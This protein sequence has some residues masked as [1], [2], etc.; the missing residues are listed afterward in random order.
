[1]N[2][3]LENIPSPNIQ[4]FQVPVLSSVLI[5]FDKPISNTLL[6]L[7]SAAN[8][9]DFWYNWLVKHIYPSLYSKCASI[10]AKLVQS[11][12]TDDEKK[13]TDEC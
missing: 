12:Y 9:F 3:R 7:I 13:S 1:M 6:E 5:K 10:N 2:F 4:L 11:L 8:D